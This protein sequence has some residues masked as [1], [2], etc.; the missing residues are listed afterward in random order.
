M[1]DA[2]H[3]WCMFFGYPRSG[4]SLVGAL[5]DAH[6]AVLISIE[7]DALAR[8]REG[9]GRAQLFDEIAGHAAR[10][11]AEGRQH[12]GYDYTV[13]GAW[14][15]RHTTLEVI[16]DKK[17]GR[18]SWWLHDEPALLDRLRETVRLPMRFIHVVRSPWDNI[19]TICT[20]G[21]ALDDAIGWYFET[22]AAVAGIRARLPAD[23]VFELH[24]E[25]LIAE[26][27]RWLFALA[28]FLG[29]A[30]ET[31][32]ADACAAVVDPRPSRSR[33]RVAWSAAQRAE[34]RRQVARFDWLD[35]GDFDDGIDPMR[36]AS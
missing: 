29:V 30:R 20:R 22:C 28:D 3:T 35:Q 33:E 32:W 25:A 10:F 5:L 1:F 27:R 14:Q 21:R 18:S 12:M 4:H 13:P 26:P 7:L 9:V 23:D 8:I 34:V 19:A 24:H 2:L 36:A 6:P 15:G 11:G 31:Q 17:G 16:G